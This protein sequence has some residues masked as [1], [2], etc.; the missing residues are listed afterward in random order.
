MAWEL[1]NN[2]GT[3]FKNTRKTSP[4]HPNATGTCMIDGKVYEV[5]AWTKEGNNGPFQSLSFKLKDDDGN[6]QGSNRSP[7]RHDYG[8]D[9]SDDIPF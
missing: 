6:H 7:G 2:S 5:S 9:P 4:K 3:L 8:D 1:R